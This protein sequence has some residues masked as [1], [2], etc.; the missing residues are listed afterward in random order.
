LPEAAL[1]AFLKAAELKPLTPKTITG[2]RKLVAD[3]RRSRQRGWFL[4][5]EES[6]EGVV[7]IS[8]PFTWSMGVYIVTVAGPPAR[9]EKKLERA[10]KLLIET[11]RELSDTR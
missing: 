8:C 3:I 5:R 2:K 1:E 10:V 9:M 4:N 6:L 7:T 11:C